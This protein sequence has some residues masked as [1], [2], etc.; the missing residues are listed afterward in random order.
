MTETDVA[1]VNVVADVTV[2]VV[3]AVVGTTP[4]AA[5]KTDLVM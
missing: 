2:A 1:V 4:A 3:A 5:N